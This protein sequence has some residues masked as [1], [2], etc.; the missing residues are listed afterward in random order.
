MI[1]FIL[2][3]LSLHFIAH[4]LCYWGKFCQIVIDNNWLCDDDL[5]VIGHPI[6]QFWNFHFIDCVVQIIGT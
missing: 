1:I 2:I 5:D 4:T 6:M 3:P